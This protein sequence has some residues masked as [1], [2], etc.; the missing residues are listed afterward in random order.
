MRHSLFLVCNWEMYDLEMS[1]ALLIVIQ[2]S[3]LSNPD[4]NPNLSYLEISLFFKATNA[5]K[6]G[7]LK[8][9]ESVVAILPD[10]NVEEISEI[11]NLRDLVKSYEDK[12]VK[13]KNEYPYNKKELLENRKS[14][15][16]YKE[17]LSELIDDRKEDVEKLKNRINK[18]IENV[19]YPKT[20]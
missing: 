4:L 13:V 10:E 14:G 8:E 3:T 12:I 16:D 7:D 11:D 5:F 2:L 18:L 1:I 19:R 15:N 17:M 6:K 20:R 9:L